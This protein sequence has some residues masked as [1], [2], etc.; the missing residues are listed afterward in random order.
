[1]ANLGGDRGVATTIFSEDGKF[2]HAVERRCCVS[3]GRMGTARH[4][5]QYPRRGQPVR[6]G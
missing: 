4:Q 1:M 3:D 6:V 5:V 2:S